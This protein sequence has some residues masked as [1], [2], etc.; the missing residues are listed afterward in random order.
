MDNLYSAAFNQ[1]NFISG[2]PDPRTGL[3]S[4]TITLAKLTGNGGLGPN[5]D[6]TLSFDPMSSMNVGNTGKGLTR[7]GRGWS[8]NLGNY[9]HAA[10]Q[11]TLSTK[12]SFKVLDN[13]WSL[14]HKQRDI[15]VQP[16]DDGETLYVIH[17][18]GLV[19][20]LTFESDPEESNA[21]LVQLIQDDGRRLDFHYR[22]NE[23][24]RLLEEI[25][26]S[27]GDILVRVAYDSQTEV[28]LYPD[29]GKEK[30]FLLRIDNDGCLSTLVLPDDNAYEFI[31]TEVNNNMMFISKIGSPTGQIEEMFYTSAEN[32]HLLPS[33][34]PVSLLP[35]IRDYRIIA[36]ADQPPVLMH[37]D[38]RSQFDT[39][40][41]LGENVVQSWNANGDN[42]WDYERDYRYGSIVTVVDPDGPNSKVQT[43]R[44]NKFHQLREQTDTYDGGTHIKTTSFRYYSH[45]GSEDSENSGESTLADQPPQYQQLKSRTVT[46]SLIDSNTGQASDEQSFEETSEFDE[47]GNQTAKT[48][49][50]GVVESF[51]YYDA[52]GETQGGETLCPPDPYGFV[53]HLKSH[54]RTPA[55]I[56]TGTNA[57]IITDTYRYLQ[58]PALS[59]PVSAD[60]YVLQS[61]RNRGGLGHID[62]TY[63]NDTENTDMH[64]R[65][66]QQALTLNN[67]ITTTD[68]AYAIDTD[69]KQETVTQTV[70]GH[71]ASTLSFSQTVSRFNGKTLQEVNAQGVV[72]AYEYEA[73]G[74]VS[75]ETVASGTP[76]EAKRTYTYT[77]ADIEVNRSTDTI[78]V[79]SPAQ[80]S[81]I[82]A[83]EQ[84]AKATYDGLSRLVKIECQDTEGEFVTLR[85]KIYN[86]LGQLDTETRYDLLPATAGRDLVP[87]NTQKSYAYDVWGRPDVVT[88]SDGRRELNQVDPFTMTDVTGIEGEGLIRT[89]RDLFNNPTK[90]ENFL[91]RTDLDSNTLSSTTSSTYDG[92]GRKLSDT[93]ALDNVT[94]YAYD[95]FNRVTQVTL[96]D[97]TVQATQYADHSNQMLP[98][99]VTLDSTEFATQSF[100]GLDRVTLSTVAGRASRTTYDDGSDKP[101]TLTIPT[102]DTL[103][104][105][106][107]PELGNC[108]T[109]IHAMEAGIDQTFDYDAISSLLTKVNNTAQDHEITHNA[110]GFIETET[111]NKGQTDE[112]TANYDYS[113]GGI[114]KQFND[115]FGDSHQFSYDS[116]GRLIGV[117]QDNLQASIMYDDSGRVARLTIN[118]TNQNKSL[119]SSLTYD[120]FG[121]EI[122]RTQN[123]TGKPDRTLSQSY[124]DKGRV[125][126]RTLSTGSEGNATTLREES[127]GYDVRDRLTSYQCTGTELPK[128][129]QGKTIQ[130]Q[131]FTYDKWNNILTYATTF[132]GGVNNTTFT[133]DN[134]NDPTQLTG[135][136]NDHADYPP[137]ATLSYDA[138]GRMTQDE[139]GRQLSYDVLGRLV[140]VQHTDGRST[141]YE[142]DGQG[143][144]VS[145]TLVSGS[146][147]KRYYR[148]GTVTNEQLDE[149]LTTYLA[150]GT[151][152]LASRTKTATDGNTRLFGTDTQKSVV[153][154]L[155]TTSGALTERPYTPYGDQL[156]DENAGRIGFNGELRDPDTGWYLLGN[157]Y[158]AYNP[159]LMRFNTPDSS[160]PFSG[161][162]INP[163]VYCLGNPV[164]QLDPSGH[165]SMSAEVDLGLNVFNLAIGLV[166]LA[167][168]VAS[169]GSAFALLGAGLGIA[170]AT[171]GV[172]ADS[173]TIQDEKTG[174]DRSATAQNLGF[175]SGITGIA[176]LVSGGLSAAGESL[177]SAKKG[178]Q[179]AKQAKSARRALTGLDDIDSPVV[180]KSIR[181]RDSGVTLVTP[182]E[183]LNNRLAVLEFSPR[184]I[185]MEITDPIL[186]F[187]GKG[188]FDGLSDSAGWKTSYLIGPLLTIGTLASSGLLFANT[189]WKWS[190]QN[191]Q[192]SGANNN[193]NTDD[194]QSQTSANQGPTPVNPFLV[195]GQ[196]VRTPIAVEIAGN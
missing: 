186:G 158:R 31:Y 145:Q 112:K 141:T 69:S 43:N 103:N 7:V 2:G 71:D 176:S 126:T 62:Y 16:S 144:L 127:F 64:G 162:G 110:A 194:S 80:L 136:G 173:I 29:T 174:Q 164:N 143:Q 28:T 180:L 68:Y 94:G 23:G 48:A 81:I 108:L 35:V 74:R 188:A 25:V 4:K 169:G 171:L 178:I 22:L 133:Y 21:N 78:T 137:S 132:E 34:A 147:L 185:A 151:Q 42:L 9:S 139:Q 134:P 161:G 149:A 53:R 123:Y 95:V 14:S 40:N 75:S 11:L 93:D 191:D 49:I 52:A 172:A 18:E 114:L 181:S 55:A 41:F 138:V 193:T 66:I 106:Y 160:S 57:D 189:T 89:T 77:A 168:I 111:F 63:H 76:H 58:Q 170:S 50:S 154:E 24:Q 92:L 87:T 118:D 67:L 37:F 146:T 59:S 32:G 79:N 115:V 1:Q 101:K 179:S 119:T 39:N 27:Q 128:N 183:I 84:Q 98:T 61:Q 148:D 129:A 140:S 121:R 12:Q 6:L 100:D 109:R 30:R 122:S 73:L 83:N 131:T 47:Y 8:F 107:S 102:D 196:S 33:G 195:R 153:A 105:S 99:S 15:K 20:V 91:S 156:P 10:N 85:E 157:G 45:D 82:D 86:D 187:F 142:Y 72:T 13:N 163:Y 120:A 135:I 96:P 90:V 70:R 130:A 152:I 88:H 182:D 184:G 19:E 167:S 60:Y 38:F 166:A 177:K 175:A 65:L 54:T 36:G 46:L 113:L 17:K 190:S 104:F 44:F 124:D 5:F 150:P 117:T 165:F 125:A 155:D 116:Q 56:A 159:T 192:Q 97:G 3:V 51:E 26:N